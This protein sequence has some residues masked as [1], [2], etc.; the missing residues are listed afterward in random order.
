MP[1]DFVEVRCRECRKKF[2]CIPKIDDYHNATSKEDGLCSRCFKKQ[3][4]SSCGNQT[5]AK[6]KKPPS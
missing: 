5:I 6:Q 1:F 2:T 4:A 3:D